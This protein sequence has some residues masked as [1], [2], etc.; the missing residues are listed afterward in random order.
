MLKAKVKIQV[1]LDAVE[2][3]FWELVNILIGDIKNLYVRKLW[4]ML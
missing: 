1:L 2:T 4:K 3:K